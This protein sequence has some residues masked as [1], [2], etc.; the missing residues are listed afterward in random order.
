MA[1][2]IKRQGPLSC[3]GRKNGAVRKKEKWEGKKNK[4]KKSGHL[5]KKQQEKKKKNKGSG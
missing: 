2:K 3:T 1:Q 4:G 5:W